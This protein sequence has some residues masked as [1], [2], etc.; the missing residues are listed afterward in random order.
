MRLEQFGG[1]AREAD[2]ALLH[3]DGALG[4]AQSDVHRL[5][6]EDDRG[7][8]V[9]DGAHDVEQPVDDRR[10]QAERQLVDHQQLAA[11]R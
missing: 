9:V 2:L 3:E 10:R 5:L 1:R 4:E 11:W 7:A 6:D 8:A